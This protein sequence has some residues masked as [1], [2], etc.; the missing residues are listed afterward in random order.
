ML[1]PLMALG[2]I[3][4]LT[5]P[6]AAG[7]AGSIA[8]EALYSGKLSDGLAKLEPFAAADDHQAW[9]GIGAIRLARTIERFAQTLYRHGFAIEA[10]TTAFGMGVILPIPQNPD[11]EPFDYEGVRSMLSDLVVGLDAARPAFETAAQ[12]GGYV[13]ALNP[14][15]IRIDANGD[16]RVEDSESLAGLLALWMGT[17]V[18]ELLAPSQPGGPSGFDHIGLDRADGYW[19]AGYTQVIASQADFLLAHDFSEFANATFHRLFP[20]AG[21]PM[22]DYAAGGM[23]LDP[24]IDTAIADLIAGIHTM[25]WPVVDAARLKGVR[26]RMLAVL[27]YSDKNWAAILEETDNDHELVPSPKQTPI[28]PGTAVDDARV[29]AWLVTLEKARDVL[30]GRLLVP[31]WRFRQGFD[32]K[33]YFETA[34]E[35]NLVMILTGM[36]ALPFLAEGRVATPEDFQAIQDAFGSDWVGYA[37]WFN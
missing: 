36:G 33:A 8:I 25:D 31:H 5:G 37:F 3:A 19:F 1:K 28:I 32:V 2:A 29:A 4:M 16:G 22:Q 17:S 9:F 7:Q 11:P 34:T 30:E 14:L 15:K 6:V 12:A 26:E 18:S 13:I 21:F 10:G 24:E 20:R 23:M 27:D 35:T